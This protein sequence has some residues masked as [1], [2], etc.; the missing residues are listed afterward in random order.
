MNINS[1][2]KETAFLK[3]KLPKFTQ[4]KKNNLESHK[5]I[6]EVEFVVRTIPPKKTP[7]LD[8]STGDST[9]HL[10]KEYINST[11]PFS[12]VEKELMNPTSLV[13]P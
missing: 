4:E 10:R 2:L 6:K 12:K 1:D 9:K 11:H 5:S 8:C 7:D 3:D 13:S